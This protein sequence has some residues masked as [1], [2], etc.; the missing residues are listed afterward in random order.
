MNNTYIS[1]YSEL[2]YISHSQTIELKK[3]NKSSQ[4]LLR[5]SRRMC[6]EVEK[7][8]DILL[9]MNQYSNSEQK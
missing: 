8:I 4:K 7:K 3:T 6:P 2:Q 9:S 1:V 5:L